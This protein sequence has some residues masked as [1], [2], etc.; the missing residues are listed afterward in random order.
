[1]RV[2][3]GG[4]RPIS[5][6]SILLFSLHH[7]SHSPRQSIPCVPFLEKAF[8]CPALHLPMGQSSVRFFALPHWVADP[9][10]PFARSLE[11][12]VKRT[13][14]MSTSRCRICDRERPSSSGSCARLRSAGWCQSRSRGRTR[15]RRRCDAFCRVTAAAHSLK[16]LFVFSILS[17]RFKFA[18]VSAIHSA[19]FPRG[20]D[21]E[22]AY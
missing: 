9:L 2:R 16:H 20:T 17:C 14:R 15:R 4:V 3:E 6:P 8:G 5:I 7:S 10:F 22:S 21:M 18:F 19:L 13:C 11:Y 12:R 1:M